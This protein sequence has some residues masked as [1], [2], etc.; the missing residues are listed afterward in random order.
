MENS[1]TPKLFITDGY[2]ADHKEFVDPTTIENPF[3]FNDFGE[4]GAIAMGTR[5][6]V[7]HLRNQHSLVL[8][9]GA[10]KTHLH[11]MMPTHFS[12]LI[13]LHDVL[14][15]QIVYTPKFFEEILEKNLDLSKLIV[16]LQDN[17]QKD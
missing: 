5:H 7:E 14:E 9:V 16:S 3:I 8:V 13:N 15:D 6:I 17:I 12:E 2:K 10:G 4:R 11:H 1:K